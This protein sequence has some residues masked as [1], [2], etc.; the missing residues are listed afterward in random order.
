MAFDFDGI[1]SPMSAPGAARCPTE[2]C[3][4][5]GEDH[6]KLATRNWYIRLDGV[7]VTSVA[8]YIAAVGRI[9]WPFPEAQLDWLAKNMHHL[10]DFTELTDWL[11]ETYGT[12]MDNCLEYGFADAVTDWQVDSFSLFRFFFIH[13]CVNDL[14][15]VDWLNE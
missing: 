3:E 15:S 11:S 14:S 13:S 8:E 9:L 1:R 7:S 4:E 2:V 6:C 10:N 12:E 5:C